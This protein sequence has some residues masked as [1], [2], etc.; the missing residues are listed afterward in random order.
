MQ[1]PEQRRRNVQGRSGARRHVLF[2]ARSRFG[3][4][5]R[6]RE[7]ITAGA[8][9][10]DALKTADDIRRV[11]EIGV[12]DTLALDNSVA[13]SRAL[14]WGCVVLIKLFEVSDI[15]ERLQAVEA[16]LRPRGKQ[17]TIR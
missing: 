15:D 11:V 12:L 9:N 8:Y 16:A 10:I 14:F 4:W 6:R 17:R 3:R 7:Q 13:R 1:L 2:L 5:R